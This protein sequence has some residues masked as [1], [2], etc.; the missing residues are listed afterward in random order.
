MLFFLHKGWF[1]KEHN[2][3]F[4]SLVI[5]IVFLSTIF[6]NQFLINLFWMALEWHVICVICVFIMFTK[7]PANQFSNLRHINIS[8]FDLLIR[9]L[10]YL[11]RFY[12]M[13]NLVNKIK[14]LLCN[15]NNHI[16]IQTH[17]HTDSRHTD[18]QTHRHT[19]TQTHRHT[20]A[21]ADKR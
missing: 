11:L 2:L 16:D 8:P 20:Y 5:L 3:M 17:R 9:H 18:T 6:S 1:G 7:L 15:H 21:K 12:R 19:D 10:I 13:L 14:S 4:M